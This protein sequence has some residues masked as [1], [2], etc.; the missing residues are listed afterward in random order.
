LFVMNYRDE[1]YAKQQAEL[2][3]KPHQKISI[4]LPNGK[5]VEG[6]SFKTTPMEIAKQLS[7]S[8]AERAIIAKVNG[9]KWDLLRPLEEDSKLEIFDF[10]SPEGSHTFW[11]SSAH[12][13]GQAIEAQW[14]DAK[15]CI[16]PPIEDG[17]FYYDVYLNEAKVVPGDYSKLEKS[18]EKIQKEKQAFQRLVLTKQQALELFRDNKFKIEIISSKVPDN[19]VC[20]AY[21]CGPL[22]DLCK[23]PH[24]PATNTVKAMSITKHSSAYWLAKAENPSLQRVY[25]ISFPDKKKLK[26][27]KEFL[28]LAEERDHRKIGLHQKLFFFHE[29]S[30]GSCF[31]LPHGARIYNKLINFIRG[32]YTKRSYQEVITPNM[33]NSELF[34]CS[35]HYANYKEHMF[36]IE[37]EKQE[38][39]LKPMNCPSHCLMFKSTLHSYRDLPLRLADFGVLHRN[40]DSGALT[41]LTRVRRF[42]QDDAHIFCRFDQIQSEVN[43]VLDMLQHC[44]G[45]FGYK[46]SLMLSTRPEKYLGEVE[47]WNK[48]EEQLKQALD[49]FCASEE[50]KKSGQSWSLNPGDG[51]FYGP[52]ID[53]QL[54]DALR[55]KHQCAT[56]QLD[57]QLPIRFD[58]SYKADD[59]SLQRPVMVHRAILGS[60]ERM[61]AVL[62]EHT[63]GK[64]PLWLSPRQVMVVPVK[65]SYLNYANEVRELLHNAGYYVDVSDSN[66]SL[67]KKVA[68]AQAAGYNFILVVGEKEEKERTVTIRRQGQMIGK[69]KEES[70][71]E[72]KNQAQEKGKKEH[73][74][75]KQGKQGKN[76]EKAVEET[77]S[78]NAPAAEESAAQGTEDK[79]DKVAPKVEGASALENK[80]LQELLALLAE[81]V[82]KFQ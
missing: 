15:L 46:F 65:D 78:S 39:N 16:G 60:V 68:E 58:L 71:D 29:W 74:P 81:L 11:H 41:G 75:Q 53:I 56:I 19:A 67:P 43:G 27:Y 31:F 17:G 66:S 23:G 54:T 79:A 6:E 61:I 52:K 63:G 21:R 30:P 42:Q 25:G 7:N 13:L 69:V 55:R 80:T 73:K 24:V 45:I 50:A 48:A 36:S 49:T 9:E 77:A 26:E 12:L 70:E 64:W 33:F 82:A 44:Y 34:K 22:I 1:T 4:A 18:I 47:Q 59:G 57:F 20:T 2:A 40:E 3:A 28:K 14:P 37:V 72:K 8:L 51:A 5:T 76:A 62:I 35:G 32:E 38:F 10:D